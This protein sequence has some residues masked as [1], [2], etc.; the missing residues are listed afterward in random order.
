MKLREAS[1]PVIAVDTP[2]ADSFLFGMLA[3]VAEKERDSISERTKA[4]LQA[5]KVRGVKLGNPE[6]FIGAVY[7][8]GGKAAAERADTFAEKIAPTLRSMV[9]RGISLNGMARELEAMGVRTARGGA[10]TATAVRNAL[11]RL[12]A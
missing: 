8:E 3:L 9:Q 5:A 11:A 2:N 10:W 7:R 1:F 12:P 6:A 4:A